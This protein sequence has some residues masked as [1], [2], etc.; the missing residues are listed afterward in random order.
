MVSMTMISVPGAASAQSIREKIQNGETIRIGFSN[1]APWAYPGGNSEPLGSINA[2]TLDV[3]KKLGATKI[4]P[5][6]TEWGSLV[7]GLQAGRFDIITGGMYILPERC[8]NVLFSEPVGKITDG[9]VVPTG[10]PEGLHS[11][12]DLQKKGLTIA[13]GAGGNGVREAQKVGIA[14]E[15]IM[16]VAS[17]VEAVQAVKAGRADA[18]YGDYLTMKKFTGKDDGIGMADPFTPPSVGYPGL[19]F[20]PG[21]QAAVDAFNEVLKEYIGSEEMMESV[22]KYGYD[23]AT[24][25]DGPKTAELCKG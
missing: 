11:L 19:A 20:K 9:L 2:I 10:N 8:R 21:D 24:L 4:E 3:L 18:A 16:Q 23:K 15:K 22:S 13:T 7:P 12:P 6:V 1:E 5:V 17:A 14:D 25:P